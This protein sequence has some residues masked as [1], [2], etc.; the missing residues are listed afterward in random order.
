MSVLL[1]VLMVLSVLSAGMIS[2][3]AEDKEFT[4]I[5]VV[6]MKPEDGAEY[7]TTR[8]IFN[9]TEDDLTALNGGPVDLGS[10]GYEAQWGIIPATSENPHERVDG[11]WDINTWGYDENGH[12]YFATK[13]PKPEGYNTPADEYA[14][15]AKGELAGF[16]R[17]FSENAVKNGIVEDAHDRAFC[18]DLKAN[19]ELDGMDCVR[20]V[21]TTDEV[22]YAKPVATKT[23]VLNNCDSAEGWAPYPGDGLE[24][25]TEKKTE[26]T[27]SIH[28]SQGGG[29]TQGGPIAGL[30]L[31]GI[32]SISF[33]FAAN[34][35]EALSG[36][37]DVAFYLFSGDY[38]INADRGDRYYELSGVDTSKVMAFDVDAIRAGYGKGD[39]S[40]ATITT[41][42]VATGENFDITNVT[43]FYFWGCTSYD[44]SH[45]QW[46]DNIVATVAVQAD[47]AV[48]AVI[49]AIDALPEAA[50][51]R[52]ANKEAIDAAK[53][54][55]DA[56]SEEQ[57]AN[58]TNA[59]KLTAAIDALE[60]LRVKKE[61]LLDDGLTP[62]RW[63][64]GGHGAS[65]DTRDVHG[66]GNAY[67]FIWWHL[68]TCCTFATPMDITGA[69]Q[70]KIDLTGDNYD[71]DAPATLQQVLGKDIINAKGDLG[72]ALTS[73]TGK[74]PT[75][76]DN[77]DNDLPCDEITDTNFLLT[78][79][80]WTD[81][82]VR[83][84]IDE[85][86]VSG[87][88]TLNIDYSTAGEKFDAS[89]VTGIALVGKT[90]HCEEAFSGVWAVVDK[91][92]DPKSDDPAVI[93]VT[94]AIDALP[95]AKDV[96]LA[97][98]DAITAANDAYNALTAD[99]KTW[100][101][102]LN[103]LT[104]AKEA[105]DALAATADKIGVKFVW[106]YTTIY[107]DNDK[108]EVSEAKT[109]TVKAK[110]SAVGGSDQRY[111]G[112]LQL[113]GDQ[114]SNP[115]GS[116]LN[117]ADYEALE[118]EHNTRYGYDYKTLVSEI[119][120]ADA[121]TYKASFVYGGRKAADVPNA[122]LTVY[123]I[124]VYDG[125]T[126]LASFCPAEDDV[127]VDV[128][129]EQS[130]EKATNWVY[131]YGFKTLT[132]AEQV[133][134]LIDAL[135]APGS[136][137]ISDLKAL[138]AA[139]EAYNALTDEQ[140]AEVKGAEK[141]TALLA[142]K[143]EKFSN[144]VDQL[145]AKV[146]DLPE[147]DELTGDEEQT[148]AVRA[149]LAEIDTITKSLTRAQVT[150][151]K[152]KY[153]ELPGKLSKVKTAFENI[154]K[155]IGTVMCTCEKDTEDVFDFVG[156]DHAMKDGTFWMN[157]TV[158]G[159]AYPNV[160]LF[161]SVY[162]RV[163]RYFGEDTYTH[164]FNYNEYYQFEFLVNPDKD[165]T[166][167]ITH[168]NEDNGIEWQYP[169]VINVTGNE[170]Q[171]ASVLISDIG[172]TV[173]QNMTPQY[174]L[175]NVNLLH[176]G[177]ANAGEFYMKD[178]AVV[179]FG[180]AKQRDAAEKKF[181]DAVAAIGTVTAE[182]GDAIEA[183][184]TARE[185]L[186]NWINTATAENLAAS[187]TLDRA[188]LEYALLDPANADVKA[189]HE[190]IVALPEAKDVTLENKD[191][192]VDAGNA[193]DALTD[194]KKAMLPAEETTKLAAV[195]KMLDIITKVGPVK[196]LID[197]LAEPDDINYANLDTVKPKYDEAKAA[198]DDLDAELQTYVDNVDKLDGVGGK[199]TALTEDIAAAKAVED[200]IDAL[201][202]AADATADDAAAI[203]AANARF[204]ALTDAQKDLIPEEKKQKLADLVGGIEPPAPTVKYGDV[205]GNGTI[206]ATDALW[207][208][209]TFVGSR[210]LD[211]A[212]TKAA[213]VDLD[214][215][216]TAS[217]AL[218]ILQ[219]FVGLRTELPVKAATAE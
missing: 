167:Y 66:D 46:L 26:G 177:Q 85:E 18:P 22:Y 105:Y 86:I 180:Y 29:F 134:E 150:E 94:D 178:I 203:V 200:L 44:G 9:A 149:A 116:R 39:E 125:E 11:N 49:A 108:F 81:Y 67:T 57:K 188:V 164:K 24:L 48:E 172:T 102:N 187:A 121:D 97:D 53:A 126:L 74:L 135:P 199:I 69:K 91:Y 110:I 189:V 139:E 119:E 168:G 127:T 213:D 157:V 211:E 77:C 210:T 195:R 61:I 31:T 181:L 142:E 156:N 3:L 143:E 140:K 96:T 55:Y 155:V 20:Q 179:S 6:A 28:T 7:L 123:E 23:V 204:T 103:K 60:A 111:F 98:G 79:E 118:T 34:T 82:G 169:S 196:E 159:V 114:G 209:Q 165:N 191:A 56:L 151:F 146:M 63:S 40:F 68:R 62:S 206:D 70:I 47:E 144:I 202:A 162:V 117:I 93:A 214:N 171:R 37:A 58:V 33:D 45:E 219:Y 122:A 160:D 148:E 50:A 145:A 76:I 192:I 84:T 15:A 30:D 109:L 173:I 59:D 208:L 64:V 183:A 38:A 205:D 42:P 186:N 95:A 129:P 54:A 14:A 128:D 185:A 90:D 99:Q 176:I 104:A 184:K 16:V 193:F 207:A 147:P 175:D 170:W 137:A 2:T 101:Y 153:P 43:G 27:G 88:N 80:A 218:A 83:L 21:L 124:E 201:P 198:F 217:D 163:G 107:G 75:G 133:D 100:V 72:I 78:G 73:Y 5:A 120:V 141:L 115:A 10:Y 152:N 41:T 89:A 36:P 194:A 35:A 212:A 51:V 19:T 113:L 174:G 158:G 12:L 154:T 4:M 166:F 1:S 130:G 65:R 182:S 190:K 71:L 106:A 13:F 197:A 87:M 112:Y 92:E 138:A 215:Q 17:E 25:T 8:F 132:P 216:I 161:N 52:V 136:L 32:Q 131:V